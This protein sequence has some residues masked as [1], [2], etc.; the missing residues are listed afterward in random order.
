MPVLSEVPSDPAGAMSAML[1]RADEMCEAGRQTSREQQVMSRALGAAR[2]NLVGHTSYFTKKFQGFNDEL[3][4][5]LQRY[6]GILEHCEGHFLTLLAVQVPE[7][8]QQQIQLN[9]QRDGTTSDWP[10]C[11][12]N[13]STNAVGSPSTR[14]ARDSTTSG[15][16]ADA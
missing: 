2:A 12:I 13:C 16:P 5:T 8:L 7:A 15:S 9:S 1:R 11:T 3:D 14:P 4:A 6:R 10:Q